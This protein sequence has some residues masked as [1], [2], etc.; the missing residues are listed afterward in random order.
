MQ[1]RALLLLPAAA[2]VAITACGSEHALSVR[3]PPTTR[4]AQETSILR[5]G[6]LP[7]P[8]PTTSVKPNPAAEISAY[9]KAMDAAEDDEPGE[10]EA[11]ATLAPAVTGTSR[12]VRLSPSRSATAGRSLPVTVSS[13]APGSFQ[14]CVAWRESGNGRGS[15]NVYQFLPSTWSAIGMPGSPYTASRATQDAAFQ[16]LYAMAG[17]RPWAP[18]DGC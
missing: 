9:L 14:A 10:D 17:T 18:Y 2:V 11:G 1:L 13:G 4:Q 12:P 16:K 7:D 6:S 5:T 3:P 8:D 15:S